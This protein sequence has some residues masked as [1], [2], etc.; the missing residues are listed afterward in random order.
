MYTD[1]S[2][3]LFFHAVLEKRKIIH[4][5]GAYLALKY[6]KKGT[7]IRITFKVCWRKARPLKISLPPDRMSVRPF[8]CM[9]VVS[10]CIFDMNVSSLS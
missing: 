8:V 9:F 3:H 1:P 10:V 6:T 7:I 2:E 5:L 4:I